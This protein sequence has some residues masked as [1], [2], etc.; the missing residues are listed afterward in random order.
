MY[1]VVCGVDRLE[2]VHVALVIR[3]GRLRVHAL[4]VHAAVAA[5]R[6]VRVWDAVVEHQPHDDVLSALSL[7]TVDVPSQFAVSDSHLSLDLPLG[8]YRHEDTL[9]GGLHLIVVPGCKCMNTTGPGIK[10]CRFC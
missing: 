2:L 3:A 10:V 6:A 1:L 8:V 7:P 9:P 5:A 4:P